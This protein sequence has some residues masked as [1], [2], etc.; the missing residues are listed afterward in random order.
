MRAWRG[1]IDIFAEAPRTALTPA[2]TTS[3]GLD[4]FYNI[5]ASAAGTLAN[6]DTSPGILGGRVAACT[7][8]YL[9]LVVGQFA[10]RG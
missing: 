5:T 2:L 10:I 3:A 8:R 9:Q 1:H 6:S 4:A 7:A